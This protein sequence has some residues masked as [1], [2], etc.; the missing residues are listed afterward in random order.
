LFW[1]LSFPM[2]G[3]TCLTHYVRPVH[4]WAMGFWFRPCKHWEEPQHPLLCFYISLYFG[5]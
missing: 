2:G 3:S 5:C 4:A 1:T